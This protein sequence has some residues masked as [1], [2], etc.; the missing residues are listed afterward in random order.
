MTR[1][2]N[3]SDSW[4]DSF[5]KINLEDSPL[6]LH[7]QYKPNQQDH[8][9]HKNNDIRCSYDSP[10]TLQ[11]RDSIGSS[12]SSSLSRNSTFSSV[13]THYFSTRGS[14]VLQSTN[15]IKSAV[16]A[17]SQVL[18]LRSEPSTTKAATIDQVNNIPQ[19]SFPQRTIPFPKTFQ[20]Q[21][22]FN[23]NHNIASTD[24]IQPNGCFV[25]IKPLSFIQKI[26]T[27]KYHYVIPTFAIAGESQAEVLKLIFNYKDNQPFTPKEEFERTIEWNIDCSSSLVTLSQYTCLGQDNPVSKNYLTGLGQRLGITTILVIISIETIGTIY[28]L[29]NNLVKAMEIDMTEPE[30]SLEQDQY[31][32][33]ERVVVIVNQ[34]HD[35]YDQTAYS[36]RK[37]FLMNE[38]P[39]IQERFRLSQPLSTLFLSTFAYKQIEETDIGNNYQLHCQ[40]ILWQMLERH[41]LGGRWCSELISLQNR[42]MLT[43]VNT[44]KKDN[45]DDDDDDDSS[46]SSD[47][48]FIFQT[49]IDYVD[50]KIKKPEKR[51]KLI[52]KHPISRLQRRQTRRQIQKLHCHDGDDGTKLPSINKI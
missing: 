4:N 52:K 46:S 13:D 10:V 45:D 27:I 32:W 48:A 36:H 16:E 3:I 2:I 37:S 7:K 43:S 33:W 9:I 38:M 41:M 47:D 39:R 14:I 17:P 31:S 51:K 18:Q 50:G 40:R 49:V 44:L 22:E 25:P 15:S 8:V 6:D 26:D 30:K 42:N 34:Q 1:R 12:S 20:H 35:I 19:A 21:K 23:Y 5:E 29:L 11:Y 24:I 28:P